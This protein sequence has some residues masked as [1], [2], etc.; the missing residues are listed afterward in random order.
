MILYHRVVNLC[1]VHMTAVADQEQKETQLKSELD[2]GFTM[3]SKEN[4]NPES[5]EW[6]NWLPSP[7]MTHDHP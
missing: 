6:Q 1:T 2:K 5:W 3:L 7:V 4:Q